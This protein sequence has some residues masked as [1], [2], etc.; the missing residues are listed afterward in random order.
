MP[1]L[2]WMLRPLVPIFLGEI[3]DARKALSRVS[4]R[5]WADA[6]SAAKR[7]ALEQSRLAMLPQKL[8]PLSFVI[9]VGANQGQWIGSLLEFLARFPRCGYS[10]RI[11]KL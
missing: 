10:S 9:D 7:L 4:E 2:K 6:F 8:L 11:R 5:P 3:L 1:S